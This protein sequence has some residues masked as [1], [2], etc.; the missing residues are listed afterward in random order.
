MAIMLEEC[1]TEEQH[2]FVGFLC[3]KGLN[4]KIFIKK[5]FLFLL[6][7]VCRVKEFHVVDKHS[8]DDEVQT[9]TRK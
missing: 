6:G 8:V 2:Y 5:R 4:A 9:E 3:A 7:C 1:I